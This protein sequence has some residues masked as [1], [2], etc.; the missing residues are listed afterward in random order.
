M[1]FTFTAVI[2]HYL[3]A[4]KSSLLFLYKVVMMTMTITGLPMQSSGDNPIIMG[5]G[6]YSSDDPLL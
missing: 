5:L 4:L 2:L 3:V 6:I 1:V